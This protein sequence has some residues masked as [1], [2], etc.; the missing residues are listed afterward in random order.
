MKIPVL[1]LI[2]LMALFGLVACGDS[3][4][5]A[6][7]AIKALADNYAKN[8]LPRGWKL[9]SITPDVQSFKLNVDVLVTSDKDIN[10][11][12][13][14]SRMEQFSVAKLGCPLMHA[15]LQQAIGSSTRIWV[16]LRANNKELTASICPI[17]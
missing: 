4:K 10:S 8:P 13:M 3:Q 17:E 12:K 6:E 2:A 9:L 16:H 11:L 7:N 14:L 5:Q 1:K 15:G